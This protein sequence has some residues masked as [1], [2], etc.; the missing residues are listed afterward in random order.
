MGALCPG[1]DL[2]PG[3]RGPW[4]AESQLWPGPMGALWGREGLEPATGGL[5]GMGPQPTVLAGLRESGLGEGG[6]GPG[7]AGGM[8]RGVSGAGRCAA[9]AGG[10]EGR[11][12]RT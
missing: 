8:G 10:R 3:A 12:R 7:Q 5:A 9:A 6:A 11:G 1:L 4:G 2:P